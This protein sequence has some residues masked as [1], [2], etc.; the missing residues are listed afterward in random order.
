MKPKYDEETKLCYMDRDS[1]IVYIKAHAIY[2][3]MSKDAE[4]RFDNSKY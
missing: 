1:F 4:T 3:D 2:K